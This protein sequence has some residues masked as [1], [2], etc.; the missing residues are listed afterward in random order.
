MQENQNKNGFADRMKNT[1]VNRSSL[2]M[3]VALM[4]ALIVIVSV[5]VASNRS[6]KNQLPLPDTDSA[7][8]STTDESPSSDTEK[9]VDTEKPNNTTPKPQ[10]KLPTF[11]LPAKGT[12][13]AKHD[14]EL[15]VYSSTLNHYRVHL[16]ID[17]QTEE[18]APVYAA[19]DGTI[20]KIWKDDLMGYSIAVAHSGDSLTFYMNLSDELPE[21]IKE[22]ASVRS[23]QLIAN[24]GDSAM[25][26]IAEEAHLHFE[27]TVA[28]LA[29][30]PLAYFNE[31]SIKLITKQ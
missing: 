24:V 29:V 1:K 11:S 18:N 27:M 21:G 23:G 6:K 25:S 4:V 9:P 14:P 2:I 8:E 5:T 17:I 13:S 31:E 10:N 19:A 12:L 16:G 15:Q 30:D 22:G 28:D 3:A 26:E 20:E 7:S